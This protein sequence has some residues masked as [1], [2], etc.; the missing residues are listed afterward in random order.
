MTIEKTKY[1]GIYFYSKNKRSIIV[2]ENITPG[3]TFF[4]EKTV[5]ED[6]K[7]Y[8][9]FEVF[10]SKL[11]A[12]IAKKISIIP[13]KEGDKILYLGASHG[14]TPSYISDIV[15]EKG[16]IFCIDFAPRVVRDL[17]FVCEKRNNMIPILASANKPETYKNRITQVDIIYQ[18]I[19]QKNQVEI[20]FKNLEFLKQK[21][22]ALIAIKSRS[23]DVTKSPERI[24][25]EVEEQLKGKLKIIDKRELDPFQKDHCFFVCQKK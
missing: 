23:I 11:A 12:A 19:A 4:S 3:T 2:T 10:R 18:D 9:I 5:K 15:K 22:Y 7:E 1:T 14:Y 6:N 8:R 21:G 20:L 13:I 17:L 16:V 25:K 24:Y